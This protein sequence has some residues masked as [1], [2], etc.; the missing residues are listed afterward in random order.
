M[1]IEKDRLI[2]G[3]TGSIGSG[4]S[5]AA[6]RL[7]EILKGKVYKIVNDYL[8]QPL[9]LKNEAYRMSELI[10]EKAIEKN[11]APPFERKLLQEIGNKLR[12]KDTSSLAIE[13]IK[14]ID[15]VEE[16]AGEKGSLPLVI[17]GIRNVGEIAEFRKYSNFFLIGIDALENVRWERLKEEYKGSST[18]F[19]E[20]DERDH[21]ENINYGQQV[22]KCVYL[23][24]ILI[25]NDSNKFKDL[26]D[27]IEDSI[28]FIKKKKEELP[29]PDETI[30]TQAYCESLKSL[31]FKRK[32]GA[33]ITSGD[34]EIISSAFNGVPS[35]GEGS[36]G[37]TWGMCYR[38]KIKIDL[39][40][41]FK[42]C[43]KCGE[44]IIRSLS[45]PK[46]AGTIP[47]EYLSSPK[48]QECKLDLDLDTHFICKECGTKIIKEFVGGQSEKCRAL[49]AEEKVILQLSKLGT[50]VSLKDTTLYTT[51]FPC[52]LCAKKIL[53]VGINR[54]VYV[55]PYPSKE[56]FELLKAIDI[57]KFEGVKARAYFR[58]FERSK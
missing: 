22:D 56:S 24:D 15:K 42:R 47:I 20:D 7:N 13:I 41:E 6:R 21:N 51:T 23:C 50:G 31:C 45:C 5:T 9:E 32:V 49:H 39:L 1:A 43:P 8:D 54:V 14:R 37:D 4:C 26:F 12:Q 17:D 19:E 2:I 29:E 30:M 10:K 38:D 58:L 52:F 57:K 36:C 34:G 11:I 16:K 35:R 28:S 46:C 18:K 40:R 48:C 44:E 25:N 53:E 3:L 27:K 55:E 33:I